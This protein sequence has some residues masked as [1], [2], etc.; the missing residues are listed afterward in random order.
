MDDV[1]AQQRPIRIFGATRAPMGQTDFF[2]Y[3]V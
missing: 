3:A 1:R 2:Y